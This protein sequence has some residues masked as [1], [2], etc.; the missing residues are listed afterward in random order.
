MRFLANENVPL[1]AVCD[2]RA[3]GTD[4]VSASDTPGG[5]DTDVLVRAAKEGRIL[6]TFDKDF[7]YWAV[8]QCR[9]VPGVV[10]LRIPPRSSG[11]V[12]S[13][14]LKLLGGAFPLAGRFTVATPDRVRSRPLP[15]SGDIGRR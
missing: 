8:R 10:L 1:A 6:V 5:P 4:I 2:L 13:Q 11:Y 3:R 14:L 12:T 9:A 7:G 15:D